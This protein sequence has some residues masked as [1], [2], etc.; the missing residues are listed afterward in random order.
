M[1]KRIP[2]VKRIC[3][4]CSKDFEVEKWQVDNGKGKFCSHQCM[5]DSRKTKVDII[6]PN[7][8]KT[9]K[10]KPS[11]IKRKYKNVF[12]SLKCFR[13]YTKGLVILV[14][15]NCGKEYETHRSHIKHRGSSCCSRKC[16]WEHNTGKNNHLWKG[17]VK[18]W[19][20]RDRSSQKYIKW[21]ESVFARDNWTCQECGARSKA[22]FPIIIHP[23]HI[24]PYAKYPKLAYKK[25][26]G[27]TLCIECHKKIH[28]E[29][30]I[31]YQKIGRGY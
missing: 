8:K 31:T 9:F 20:R 18:F 16:H 27:R 1:S 14:C 11:T 24:K 2:R 3:Q 25:D 12:C 4:S 22:G 19:K 23:H 6:C 28:R 17:G 29:S 5:F 13:E 30:R 7:C 15:K 26:N 10:A 21:R